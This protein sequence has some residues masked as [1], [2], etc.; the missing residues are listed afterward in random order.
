M[1]MVCPQCS[2]SF[3]GGERL[4]PRCNIVL[5][6]DHRSEARSDDYGHQGPTETWQQNLWCRILVSL[7]LTQ[8]L[9]YCLNQAGIA[10]LD[11]FGESSGTALTPL[12]LVAL[13][14]FN[15]FALILTGMLVGANQENGATG[16]TLLG[17][18]N[19]LVFLFV[20]RAARDFLPL[21]LFFAQPLLQMLWGGLGGYF[22]YRIWKPCSLTSSADGEAA[23]AA[24]VKPTGQLLRGRLHLIRVSLGAAMS[25]SGLIFTKQFFDFIVHA[26]GDTY[27]ADSDFQEN[28]V[29]WQIIGLTILVGAMFAGATTTNGLKQGLFAGILTASLFIGAQVA[30]P[31]MRFEM[32]IVTAL[33]T[34]GLS[35]VGGAFGAALFPKLMKV[36]KKAIPY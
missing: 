16:G 18:A 7:L 29:R 3:A 14:L 20:F 33:V 4:C 15:A 5:L 36:R 35:V 34:L 30:N 27:K 10:W 17:L 25:L 19:G 11:F 9:A 12:G 26:S 8:G 1:A 13:H 2:Q 23:H 22:G 21:W 32:V 24:V 6:V 28:L 31:K